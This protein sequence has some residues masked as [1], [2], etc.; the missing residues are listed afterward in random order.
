[1]IYSLV[2]EYNLYRPKDVG[3]D[4]EAMVSTRWSTIVHDLVLTTATLMYHSYTI[5][6]FRNHLKSSGKVMSLGLT[7]V[8]YD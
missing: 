6:W 4:A 5:K 8:Q 1:M 2:L 3:S 7:P